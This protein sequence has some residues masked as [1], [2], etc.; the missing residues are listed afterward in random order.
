MYSTLLAA[1]GGKPPGYFYDARQGG[2]VGL[3]RPGKDSRG[4]LFPGEAV[5]ERMPIK[6]VKTRGGF[7]QL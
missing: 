5:G 1:L 3:V 7:D 4:I 2:L 6:W